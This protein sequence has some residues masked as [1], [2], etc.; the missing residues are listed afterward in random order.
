MTMPSSRGARALPGRPALEILLDARPDPPARRVLPA[1]ASPPRGLRARLPGRRGAAP[2]R[3]PRAS[4][5]AARSGPRDSWRRSSRRGSSTMPSRSRGRCSRR[6][7][8]LAA[9]PQRIHAGRLGRACV[10]AGFAIAVFGCS[11]R[12]SRSGSSGASS[13]R[14]STSSRSTTSSTPA[15]SSRNIWESYPIGWLLAALFAAALR[16]LA[17]RC[18]PA[19]RRRA[20]VAS[21]A[22]QAA[23]GRRLDRAAPPSSRFAC[24]DGGALSGRAATRASWRRTGS[25]SCSRRSGTTRSTTSPS[26][27]PRATARRCDRAH[28]L[29]AEPGASL[30]LATTRREL[31]RDSVPRGRRAAAERR[32][33]R[34]RE[35]LGAVPR[36]LRKPISG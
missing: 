28:E 24:A 2:P 14:A 30:R 22:A 36:G 4:L 7:F 10:H 3:P 20:G 31:S 15:R 33:R 16:V 26:T 29:L 13:T 34:G 25:T 17:G 9:A 12:P 1:A 19:S 8:W 27:S 6:A 11:S 23:R 35:P 5:A 18:A 32:A 21:A